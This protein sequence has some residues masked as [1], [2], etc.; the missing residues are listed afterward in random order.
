MKAAQPTPSGPPK[1][2]YEPPRLTQHGQFKDIVQ[3]GGGTKNEPHPGN[4]ASRA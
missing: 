3:G 1:K 2:A 4:P